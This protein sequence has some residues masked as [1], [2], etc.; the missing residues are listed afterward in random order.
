M[1]VLPAGRQSFVQ[2][3][4]PASAAYASGEA[5][6]LA[7][8]ICRSQETCYIVSARNDKGDC[9]GIED[10]GL[11]HDIENPSEHIKGVLGNFQISMWGCL[12][13]VIA[14]APRAIKEKNA[15]DQS[16][17]RNTKSTIDQLSVNSHRN[18]W[19]TDAD[20]SA[21]PLPDLEVWGY[22]A[23]RQQ[24]CRYDADQ[25]NGPRHSATIGTLERSAFSIPK[26]KWIA[27]P[28]SEDQHKLKP[29]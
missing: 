14:Y 16:I 27:H 6:P 4:L 21:P 23:K 12:C 8:G 5:I 9:K 26:W 18:D 28:K 3:A 29:A 13:K 1:P 10:F 19:L 2:Q 17:A 24:D 11:H 7:R 25:D 20:H 15:P 22:Q